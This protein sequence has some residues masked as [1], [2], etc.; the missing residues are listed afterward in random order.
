VPHS[1][2]DR[3]SILTGQNSLL[4]E[5]NEQGQ[6]ITDEHDLNPE[7]RLVSESRMTTDRGRLFAPS[8][9]SYL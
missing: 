5:C 4:R 8:Y 3:I 7:A 6:V 1:N 9:A 2:D